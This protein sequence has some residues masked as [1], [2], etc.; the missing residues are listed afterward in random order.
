MEPLEKR[1]E[2]IDSEKSAKNPNMWKRTGREAQWSRL[3]VEKIQQMDHKASGA[4]KEAF[5]ANSQ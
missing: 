4:F 2:P 1:S 3:K 5:T